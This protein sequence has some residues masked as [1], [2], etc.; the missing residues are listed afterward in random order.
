L[1]IAKNVAANKGQTA[2]NRMKKVGEMSGIK[3]DQLDTLLTFPE[4][5]DKSNNSVSSD[6]ALIQKHLKKK[7][8]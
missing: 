3:K 2:L 1:E 4:F 6:D 5:D 7:P 8:R